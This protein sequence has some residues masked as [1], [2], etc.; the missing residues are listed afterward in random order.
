VVVVVVVFIARVCRVLIMDAT[1]PFGA[2]GV[3]EF[4]FRVAAG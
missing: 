1:I 2:V 4:T 3:K